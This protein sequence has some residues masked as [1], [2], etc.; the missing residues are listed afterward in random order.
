MNTPS[1]MILEKS[2]AAGRC[3]SEPLTSSGFVVHH[4]MDLPSLLTG[5][6]HTKVSLVILG[7]SAIGPNNSVD[8]PR[9]IHR[10]AG[11]A[12]F[13]L[14]TERSSEQLAIS[15]LRF[16]VSG[17]VKYPFTNRELMDAV[18]SCLALNKER[19]RSQDVPFVV[20]SRVPML[21]SSSAMLELRERLA[22]VGSCDTNVLIT[23]ETGTGKELAA[24]LLH[25]NSSRRHL[26][27][28]TI[29]CAAIPDTLFESE[30]FGHE[31]GAFTGAQERKNGKLKSADRGTVFLDEIGD[32]SAYGQAKM[33]RI[34]EEGEIQR[35][36]RDE[37]LP[38]DVR[39]IAATNQPLERLVEARQFRGDLFFRLNVARIQLPSLR[40]RKEDIPELIDHYIRQFNHRFNRRVDRLSDEALDFF[41]AYDWPGNVRELKNCLEMMFVESTHPD[42]PVACLTAES[43]KKFSECQLSSCDERTQ[44]IAA[45]AETNWNKSKAADKLHWSRMTLYRKIA[46]Y[47]VG[48]H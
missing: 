39:I 25:A 16:G 41:L 31:R 40:E 11:G 43:R 14:V 27:I 37:N 33:L 46:R 17:Y 38:V 22:R 34:I 23:G 29:N 24:T 5:L 3:L 35:L 13:L 2:I 45:L 26:P 21:G 9:E 8:L 20:E 19:N 42:T 32:M 36:G 1:V 6:Q 18:N 48:S 12:S 30:L 4:A 10:T 7:P 44:L 47:N 15:A 28:L